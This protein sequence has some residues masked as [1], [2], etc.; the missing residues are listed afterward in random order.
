VAAWSGA[1]GRGAPRFLGLDD[2]GREVLSHLDG[3]VAWAPDQPAAVAGPVRAAHAWVADHRD[4][5]EA[6]F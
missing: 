6:A 2:Q 5:L 3:H 1:A 4:R